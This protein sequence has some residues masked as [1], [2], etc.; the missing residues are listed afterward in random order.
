MGLVV[1]FET[2]EVQPVRPTICSLGCDSDDRFGHAAGS[3]ERLLTG[4]RLGNQKA[5]IGDQQLSLQCGCSARSK[6][7]F[8]FDGQ[9]LAAV[10][11]SSRLTADIGLSKLLATYPTLTSAGWVSA[12]WRRF[13]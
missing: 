8:G 6:A 7:D 11:D 12:M 3:H 5:A 13:R 2:Y 9:L 4:R 1:A 10:T